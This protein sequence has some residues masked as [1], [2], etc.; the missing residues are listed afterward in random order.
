LCDKPGHVARDCKE[1]KAPIKTV[2][3]AS[4]RG[5]PAFLG[6]VQ[7][8]DADGFTSVRRGLRKQ[9]P[10]FGDFIRAAA[11][12]T[13]KSSTARTNRFRELTVDDLLAISSDE[14]ACRGGGHLLLTRQVQPKHEVTS[15][16]DFPELIP[17]GQGEIGCVPARSSPAIHAQAETDNF[18]AASH[19]LLKFSSDFH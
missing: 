15:M 18:V 1:R 19:K 10:N 7:I 3:Q 8:V 12:P 9:E 11:I 13:R 4:K 16:S 5:D 17:S 2:E 6:C 14:E